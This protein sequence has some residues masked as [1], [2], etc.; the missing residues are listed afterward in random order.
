ML[1]QYLAPLFLEINEM[2]DSALYL[3]FIKVC[4]Y[5]SPHK[6]LEMVGKGEK[7]AS[8]VVEEMISFYEEGYNGLKES[9]M[10]TY[11]YYFSVRTEN[12]RGRLDKITSGLKNLG[13]N[14]S[15]IF[16]VAS[17]DT[18]KAIVVVAVDVLKGSGNIAML[19][20]IQKQRIKNLGQSVGEY[21]ALPPGK[22]KEYKEK[23]GV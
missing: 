10:L 22:V 20:Q 6:V 12:K 19:S 18:D 5:G 11:P 16:Q 21:M 1:N 3:E 15:D 2:E 14:I 7:K 9:E 23:A 8:E 17:D 4:G 13:L